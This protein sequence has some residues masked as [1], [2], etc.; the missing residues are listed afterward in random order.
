MPILKSVIIQSR[1]TSSVAYS[2]IILLILL[3]F[4]ASKYFKFLHELNEPL[5][6]VC[7]FEFGAKL[8]EVKVKLPI[9]A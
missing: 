4:D 7:N 1:N 3:Q 9:K 5:P 8:T 6:I 2:D